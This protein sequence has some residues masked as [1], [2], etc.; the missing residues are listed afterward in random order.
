M[1]NRFI[2][3]DYKALI[4]KNKCALCEITE[5]E[6]NESFIE[7][8]HKDQDQSNN[9]ISN[10]WALCK[11][12]HNMKIKCEENVEEETFWAID[13]GTLDPHVESINRLDNKKNVIRVPMTI[14]EFVYEISLDYF[15]SKGTPKGHNVII[16]LFGKKLDEIKHKKRIEIYKKMYPNFEI[17][18]N[19]PDDIK[20]YN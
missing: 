15:W 10:L 12:C 20:D 9:E 4:P 16:N 3:S 5:K 13:I 18:F 11:F 7:I 2:M 1:K 14:K 6:T 19:S 8:N 17:K